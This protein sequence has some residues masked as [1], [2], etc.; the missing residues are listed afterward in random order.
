MSWHP[1]GRPGAVYPASARWTT[2]GCARVPPEGSAARPGPA[3]G[4]RSAGL[5]RHAAGVGE[6]AHAA[7]PHGPKATLRRGRRDERSPE[8]SPEGST[9]VAAPANGLRPGNRWGGGSRGERNG[10]ADEPD[11][12]DTRQGARSRPGATRSDAT[13]FGGGRPHRGR[14]SARPRLGAPHRGP[15]TGVPGK[16]PPLEPAPAGRRRGRRSRSVARRFGC[17]DRARLRASARRRARTPR[18]R[19]SLAGRPAQGSPLRTHFGATGVGGPGQ[20]GRP[21]DPA[22]LATR[23]RRASARAPARGC[24]VGVGW[25]ARRAPRRPPAL[26]R[27]GPR[28]VGTAGRS[29]GSEAP[30][31][32]GDGLRSPPARG[33]ALEV[34]RL[35]RRG[36]STYP[37]RFGAEDR[38][39][40]KLQVARGV[41]RRTPREGDG[42]RSTAG[43]RPRSRGQP[44]GPQDA[45]RVPHASARRTRPVRLCWPSDGYGGA[46][47]EQATGFGPLPARGR[48]VEAGV[49]ARTGP[50][51]RLAPRFGAEQDGEREHAGRPR[52]RRQRRRRAAGFGPV[53]RGGRCAEVVTGTWCRQTPTGASA[54]ADGSRR[55]V[56]PVRGERT[57]EGTGKERKLRVG[58]GGPW[59]VGTR[60][61]P[62]GRQASAGPVDEAGQAPD[63]L[64]TTAH[65]PRGELRLVARVQAVRRTPAERA[66]AREAGA[67]RSV[68]SRCRR[69]EGEGC[70]PAGPEGIRK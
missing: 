40:R 4:L 53:L 63:M 50:L 19:G 1:I 17:T 18:S 54:P 57:T 21:Q 39:E 34:G 65:R 46:R 60:Q 23:W 6:P 2:K 45:H 8:A 42:L 64:R 59:Q 33:R 22:V 27:G 31:A 47:H 32:P 38:G 16:R 69:P 41:R 3:G 55:Q 9:P 15:E 36:R 28:R 51:C 25:L 14:A 13:R 12:A 61:A 58:A 35:A 11:T 62:N 10:V 52:V 49:L 29:T 56:T 70:G 7:E 68:A 37:P 5:D 43:S 48:T 26:R 24:T 66:S 67:R 30:P 20:A 44:A